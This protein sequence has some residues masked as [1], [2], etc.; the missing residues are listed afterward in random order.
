[1]I[2]KTEMMEVVQ[3]IYEMVGPSVA[4]TNENSSAAKE[5][6]EKVFQVRRIN[7]QKYFFNILKKIKIEN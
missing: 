6:V 7:I 2:T 3:S 5:H 1:M 4:P